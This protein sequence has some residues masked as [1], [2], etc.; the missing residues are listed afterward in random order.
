[1]PMSREKITQKE[2]YSE[3]I[4]QYSNLYEK[5]HLTH[6]PQPPLLDVQAHEEFAVRLG[7]GQAFDEKF[8]RVGRVLLAQDATQN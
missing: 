5:P 2:K 6:K 4:K 1:M 7:F 8:H 3:D